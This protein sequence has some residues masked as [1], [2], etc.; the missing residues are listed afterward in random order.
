M[1]ADDF[2]DPLSAAMSA[3]TIAGAYIIA[4][5]VPLLPLLIIK[6][7]GKALPY[8]I[9]SSL[10]SLAI[11]GFVKGKL[12]GQPALQ[13]AAKTVITGALSALAA[14]SIAGLFR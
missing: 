4:G 2:N 3:C 13:L 10:S 1:I 12:T 8:V 6:D 7:A 5:L 9:L 11:F 14:Y